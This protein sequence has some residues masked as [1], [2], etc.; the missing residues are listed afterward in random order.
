MTPLVFDEDEKEKIS[1]ELVLFSKKSPG[2]EVEFYTNKKKK[3]HYY[4]NS[5]AIEYEGRKCLRNGVRLNG[6]QERPKKQLRG[7]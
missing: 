6:P 7:K 4:I 2:I 3:V 1:T 5:L